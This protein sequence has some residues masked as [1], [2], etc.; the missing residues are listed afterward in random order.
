FDYIPVS[1]TLVFDDFEMTKNILVFVLP[2][3][4]PFPPPQIP[5]PVFTAE[6]D[7]YMFKDFGVVLS[8]PR[9][10]PAESPDVSDPRT[11]QSFGAAIVRMWS[12]QVDP[13][14][15]FNI[16]SDTNMPPNNFFVG[17]SN[18]VFNFAKAHYRVPEDVMDFWKHDVILTVE[19]SGTN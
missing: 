17:P 18:S 12:S 13:I 10:D 14:F 7:P 8:N 16:V 9:R 15:A 19:R 1:G 5:S 2:S 6:Q 3:F 11:D 4:L